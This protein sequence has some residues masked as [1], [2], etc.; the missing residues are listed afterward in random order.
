MT[1]PTTTRAAARRAEDV[2]ASSTA[3]LIT[4]LICVTLLV[5]VGLAAVVYLEANNLSPDT[6]V[7]VLG[8]LVVGQLVP[9]VLARTQSKTTAA[10]EST[11][12][13]V[14]GQVNRLMVESGVTPRA[15]RTDGA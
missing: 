3:L 8:T 15:P 4:A 13:E 2:K 6:V 1:S 9:L 14:T 5:C 11:R 10:V 12:A 7:Y